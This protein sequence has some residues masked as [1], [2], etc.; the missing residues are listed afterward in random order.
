MQFGGQLVYFVDN[1]PSYSLKNK[2]SLM[3][4]TV[5]QRQGILGMKINTIVESQ[6]DGFLF[7]I[8]A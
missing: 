5:I 3:H 8:H 4:L 7:S 2:G 6:L 1:T